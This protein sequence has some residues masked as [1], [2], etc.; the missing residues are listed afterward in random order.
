MTNPRSASNAWS[1][2]KKK[3]FADAPAANGD[4]AAAQTPG[5]RKRKAAAPKNMSAAKEAFAKDDDDIS[6]EVDA[7]ATPSKKRSRAKPKP[8]AKST[9]A[10]VKD[11]ED[12]SEEEVKQTPVKEKAVKGKAKNLK[13]PKSE[14]D[15]DGPEGADM[16]QS[17]AVDDD[18][19]V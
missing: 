7:E 14:D 9:P 12:S 1:A 17:F 3:L 16:A 15:S 6:D 13:Q 4:G 2:I 8:K 5:S 18:G 19:A 10:K 11:E